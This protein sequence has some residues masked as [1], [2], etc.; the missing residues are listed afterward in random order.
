MESPLSSAPDHLSRTSNSCS[1]M[2]SG[3]WIY[4]IKGPVRGGPGILDSN[5]KQTRDSGFKFQRGQDSGFKFQKG[6]DSG[7]RFQPLVLEFWYSFL[8]FW[9]SNFKPIF[10]DSYFKMAWIQDSNFK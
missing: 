9:D 6:K 8:N 2:D 10:W 1:E 3:R 7:F 5:F 4:Q